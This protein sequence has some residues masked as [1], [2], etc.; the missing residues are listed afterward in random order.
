MT[1][2]EGV[3]LVLLA[4]EQSARYSTAADFSHAA[5]FLRLEN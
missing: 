1:F 4:V 5:V 2:H 3:W